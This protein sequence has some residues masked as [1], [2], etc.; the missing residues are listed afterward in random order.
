MKYA[1]IAL[2][3]FALTGCGSVIGPPQTLEEELQSAASYFNTAGTAMLPDEF[4][5][6]RMEAE[7]IGKDL[8]VIRIVDLPSGHLTIDPATARQKFRPKLCDKSNA[9]DLFDRGGK[10]RFEIVSNIGVEA[11]AFQIV[12]C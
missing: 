3:L 8:I 1:S 9:Q 7:V 5:K 4:G 10:I 2:A 6:A 12:S 11:T